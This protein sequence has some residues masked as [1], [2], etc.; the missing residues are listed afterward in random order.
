MDV[1]KNNVIIPI[2]RLTPIKG[3]VRHFLIKDIPSLDTASHSPQAH[4]SAGP[5]IA[6]VIGGSHQS[7]I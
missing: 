5:G 1:H 4:L 7:Q 6:P 3:N 2:F